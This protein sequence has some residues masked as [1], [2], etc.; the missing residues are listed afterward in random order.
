MSARI[1]I[2]AAITI[3]SAT[4]MAA[5]AKPESARSLRAD[6]KT[7]IEPASKAGNPT[8]TIRTGAANII[9]CIEA[10]LTTFSPGDKVAST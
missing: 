8:I 1:A 7:V 2:K 10:R 9:Q 5:T 3:K 6:L 4:S